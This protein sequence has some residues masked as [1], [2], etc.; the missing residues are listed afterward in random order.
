MLNDSIVIRNGGEK[1]IDAFFELYWISSVEHVKYN[2][3]LDALKSKEQCREYIADRQRKY[4][5]DK[6]Q[7]FFIA[8][9]KEK[10]IGVATGHIGERD[11][12][13]VYMV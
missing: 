11:E 7:I 1:D 13:A 10:I 6:N 2:E 8:E 12:A 3:E 4:L 9:D 5:K